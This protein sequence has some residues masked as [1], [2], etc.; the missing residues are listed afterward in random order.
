MTARR[1][2]APSLSRIAAAI[3]RHARELQRLAATLDEL[4]RQLGHVAAQ[5][6]QPRAARRA[7]AEA[8][9]PEGFADGL[10][11]AGQAAAAD[12]LRAL[13]HAQLGEVY[14]QVGGRRSDRRRPKAWLVKQILW[15]LFD[16]G[17]GHDIVRGGR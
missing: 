13:R 8:A 6:G 9:V 2:P 1:N 17:G 15:H 7:K 14:V 16:F 5:A 4:A 10:R 3:E 12:M 11:T